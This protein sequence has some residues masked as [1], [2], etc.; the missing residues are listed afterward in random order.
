VKKDSSVAVVMWKPTIKKFIIW[1]RVQLGGFLHL[2]LSVPLIITLSTAANSSDK[3]IGFEADNVVVK[4]NDGSL[5]ATGNVELKQ[6]KNTLR[7][8]EVTYYREQN[9]AIARGNVV[10]HD[11]AGTVT[12]ATVM[13]LDTEFS[14]ILAETI[15][16]KY[17]NGN[18]MTADNADRVTGDKGVF[19]NSRFT[20]C[21]CDFINGEQPM[22]DIK[23]SRTVRNEKTQTIT[24]YNMRMNVMN[25]PIGYLPFLSHPDWTVRR[26]SGFLTPSFRLSSDLGF[27]PTIPYYHV[28]DD[29]SDIEVTTQKYQYR[30]FG[31]KARHRKLWDNSRLVTNIYGANVETYKKKRELVGGI[32]SHFSSQIGNGWNLNAY[33]QRA[34]QDT[35]MR[36]YG[37]N[38]N[39]SLKSSILASKTIGNRYYLVEASDRQSMLTGD[40]VTNEQT[41]LPSI[42]YEKEE[43][44]WRQNQWLR[45]EIN[46]L[47]LDNDQ[48]YDLARW[49]G[50]LELSEE[51]QTPLGVTSYKGNL[52]GN[53]YSLQKKPTAATSA[54]GDYTF[55]TPALSVGWRFPIAM[56]SQ[57]RNAIFE[58]QVKAVYVGG[59]DRTSKIP[60][61]DSNEYRIDEANLFL[62]NRYQG[63]DYVLPGTRVDVG[64]SAT[65]KDNLLGD[66]SGFLGLSRRLSGGVSS[67]LNT[68]QGDKN[69]DYVAS[70]SLDPKS[71]FNLRWSG[72]LSSKDLTLNESKTSLSSGIGTGQISLTHNQLAKAYF[73]DTDDDLEEL[74]STYQQSFAGGWN[75]SATQL[76]DLSYGK[77]TRKKSTAS[78]TWNGGVQDCIFVQIFYEHDP[79]GDRDIDGVDQLNFVVG[80]SELGSLTQSALSSLSQ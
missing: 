18:W 66:F 64:M 1:G 71:R 16:S 50:V 4:Q 27:S 3:P 65:A 22:W 45:T 31:L 53:Y 72:R 5:F 26:R 55:L 13:E 42:F 8:D 44:G 49:N 39:T 59:T 21:N 11:A 43:K 19:K 14:H 56:T 2:F 51:F 68:D 54:L 24:H 20:P 36:R 77:T 60:N 23:A 63:K 37:F 33:L 58:P 52:T 70:L 15:I 79:V 32:D 9:K 46:A 62:L 10:H 29:T 76:W 40:K 34:S 41:I 12:R 30:G 6:G 38:Q 17:A 57:N 25:V 80:F 47:H 73:A 69:S 7:A 35:F 61:R 28:I 67:G 48:G 75:F 74:S 78:L